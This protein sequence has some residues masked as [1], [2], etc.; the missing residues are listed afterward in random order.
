MKATYSLSLN[1]QDVD[2][3]DETSQTHLYRHGH[4]LRSVV[5]DS[6]KKLR[7]QNININASFAYWYWNFPD[8]C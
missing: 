5:E 4:S 7:W 2:E 3:E 8:L 6:S 1:G